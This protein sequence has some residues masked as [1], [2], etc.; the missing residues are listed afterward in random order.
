MT[1]TGMT[2]RLIIEFKIKILPLN[3]ILLKEKAARDPK[4]RHKN[5]EVVVKIRV[6]ASHLG[7]SSF[8]NTFLNAS[9]TTVWGNPIL[10]I[11]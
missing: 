11:L 4:S 8:R 9:R 1:I 2:I 7:R 10:L 6:F 5:T 3:F